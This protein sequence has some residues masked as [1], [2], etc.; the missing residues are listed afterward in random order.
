MEFLY[1]GGIYKMFLFFFIAKLVKQQK[2]EVWP[3]GDFSYYILRLSLLR[4]F[5]FSWLYVET[6]E[7]TNFYIFFLLSCCVIKC[8]NKKNI[9]IN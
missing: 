5:L 9:F 7:V 3:L 6:K 4:Q 1:G 2:Q 8:K